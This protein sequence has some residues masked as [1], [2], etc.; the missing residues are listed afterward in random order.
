MGVATKR[1]ADPKQKRASF[2]DG[3]SPGTA[4]RPGSAGSLGKQK[5]EKSAE[6]LDNVTLKPANELEESA[7]TQLQR[8]EEL[9]QQAN[10]VL[11]SSFDRQLGDALKS[12]IGNGTKEQVRKLLH[13]MDSNGDGV[14]QKIELRQMVRNNLKI[15]AENKT[16][17]AFFDSIDE[18]KS[19]N[20]ELGELVQACHML[21]QGLME[22]HEEIETLQDQAEHVRQRAALFT[23]A[24]QGMRELEEEETRLAQLESG[25]VEPAAAGG[26][27]AA[28]GGGGSGVGL[29]QRIGIALSK[30]TVT[31]AEVV[32]RLDG[33]AGG[34]KGVSPGGG[35][36][37]GDFARRLGELGVS[38]I[39]GEAD[40][41]FDELLSAQNK[42]EKRK[43]GKELDVKRVAKIFFE[44]AAEYREKQKESGARLNGLR[45]AAK[46]LQKSITAAV[47]NSFI[48][49]E[50]SFQEKQMA[51][52]EATRA[53]AEA[54]AAKAAAKAAAA[55]RKAKE[56][57]EFDAKIEA[58]RVAKNEEAMS[59]Y[60]A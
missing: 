15:K 53:K 28:E 27:S 50:N 47:E 52:L 40:A 22:A 34:K 43:E 49:H 41:L 37:R 45:L 5:Q 4:A 35:I 1:R 24:A 13:E 29:E 42:A 57:A 14:L 21:M 2:T 59:A 54:E 19:G 23:Q 33:T 51:A 18:D 6:K 26:G 39:A 56:K 46:K 12:K 16:I 8:A 30:K 32:G 60:T 3:S 25:G 55:E 9:E 31:S 17:D 7:Q 38:V 58:R 36:A 10:S 11:Y 44:Y 20:I 48:R